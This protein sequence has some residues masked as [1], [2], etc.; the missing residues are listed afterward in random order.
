MEMLFNFFFFH[1]ELYWRF[2]N[3]VSF[4]FFWEKIALLVCVLYLY[5]YVDV[6][7]ELLLCIACLR[8]QIFVK[9]LGEA[10]AKN[11]CEGKKNII[12]C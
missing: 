5:C 1:L 7:L 12:L 3:I 4:F 9:K 2:Y 6:D 11:N 8:Y 10:V